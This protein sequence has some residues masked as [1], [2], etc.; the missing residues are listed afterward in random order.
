M[1]LVVIKIAPGELGEFLCLV[2]PGR[3]V[4]T[5]K[6]GVFFQQGIAVGREHFAVGVEALS[7]CLQSA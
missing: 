1:Q 5:V 7:L 2:L 3:P 6:M 4:V